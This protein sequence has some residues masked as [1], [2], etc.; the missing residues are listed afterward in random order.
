MRYNK[1]INNKV[2]A[3]TIVATPTNLIDLSLELNILKIPANIDT[4][5]NKN[6]N[7]PTP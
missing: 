3:L 4:S 5:I 7:T 6:I 1:Y 2:N